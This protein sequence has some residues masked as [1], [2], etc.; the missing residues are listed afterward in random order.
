MHKANWIVAPSR[1]DDQHVL[2]DLEV[3]RRYNPQRF[4]MEQLTAVLY[5]DPAHHICV[6]YKDLT[7]D[8]FW[9]R[10]QVSQSP[11]MPPTL[12]CEAAAQLANYYAL[13]HQLYKAQGGSVGLRNVRYRGIARPGERLFVLVRLRE[14]GGTRLTCQFQ[15]ALREQLVCNGILL[16]GVFPWMSEQKQSWAKW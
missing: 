7:A 8:E 3:I 14:V 13:K 12:M 2:A 6:G 5:E 11:I 1:L 10:G 15:C 9:V 16:C 4:E